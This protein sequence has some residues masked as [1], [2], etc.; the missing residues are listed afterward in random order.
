MNETIGKP[1]VSAAFENGKLRLS[2]VG[3]IDHHSAREIREEMDRA[4]YLYK[5]LTV[6][7]D[8]GKV[9]FM[10]SAGLGLLMGRFNTA[11]EIGAV[12]S[13]RSPSEQIL[14]IMKMSGMDRVISVLREPETNQ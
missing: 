10:D 5:P 12:L 4:I 8:L 3:E 14:R 7:V 6:S 11:S 13:V 1:S 9:S 2:L